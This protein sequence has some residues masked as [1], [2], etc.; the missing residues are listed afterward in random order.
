MPDE[1]LWG[2]LERRRSALKVGYC[3]PAMATDEEATKLVHE[4][5]Y[6]FGPFQFLEL[7]H[8]LAEPPSWPVYA[9]VPE[10]YRTVGD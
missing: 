2:E 8:R 1:S 7:G 9:Q 6:E 5:G 4:H 10:Q 3:Y